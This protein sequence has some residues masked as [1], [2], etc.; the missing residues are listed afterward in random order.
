MG[1]IRTAW[2]SMFVCVCFVLIATD[3]LVALGVD[4]DASVP[5]VLYREFGFGSLCLHRGGLR[6]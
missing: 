3:V 6:R 5:L 2:Y 1:A 4:S